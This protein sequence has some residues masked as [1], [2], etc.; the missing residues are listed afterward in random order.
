MKKR[1]RE[2]KYK[3]ELRKEHHQKLDDTMAEVQVNQGIRFASWA[4]FLIQASLLFRATA[5]NNLIV[6]YRYNRY[7][8]GFKCPICSRIEP[9]IPKKNQLVVEVECQCGRTYIIF[10]RLRKVK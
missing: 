7:V 3:I 4:D 1:R 2:A 8:Y 9:F 5:Q 10:R 6:A